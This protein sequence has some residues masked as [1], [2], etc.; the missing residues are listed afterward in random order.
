MDKRERFNSCLLHRNWPLLT[1][2]RA[3]AKNVKINDCYIIKIQFHSIFLSLKEKKT[4]L[5]EVDI[6]KKNRVIP[7]FSIQFNFVTIFLKYHFL[8]LIDLFILNNFHLNYATKIQFCQHFS[9]MLN[10]TVVVS[11]RIRSIFCYFRTYTI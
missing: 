5:R 9:P 11:T 2:A 7:H 1:V 10:L 8:Q 3:K 4:F 6:V